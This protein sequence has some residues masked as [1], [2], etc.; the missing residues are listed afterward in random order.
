VVGFR[1]HAG[2]LPMPVVQIAAPSPGA[3]CAPQKENGWR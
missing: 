2:I 3:G 1:R